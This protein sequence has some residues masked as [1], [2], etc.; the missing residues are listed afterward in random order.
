M[1]DDKADATTPPPD[2]PSSGDSKPATESPDATSSSGPGGAKEPDQ[3]DLDEAYLRGRALTTSGAMTFNRDASIEDLQ[4]GDRYIYYNYRFSSS[5]GDLR[6]VPVRDEVLQWV[7]SRYVPVVNYGDLL[8]TLERMQVLVLNGRPDTGRFTT[9]LRLLNAFTTGKISRVDGSEELAKFGESE[10]EDDHGY[11]VELSQPQAEALTERVLEE[12]AGKLKLKGAYFVVICHRDGQDHMLGEFA[13]PCLPPD[14]D[15]LILSHL[16]E[17]LRDED[18]DI[19]AVIQ[20]LNAN[21]GLRSALAAEPKPSEV[22]QIAGFLAEMARGEIDLSGVETRAALLVRKQVEEWFAELAGPVSTLP[23]ALRLT[24]FRISLAVFNSSEYDVVVNAG[25]ALATKLLK[26]AKGEHAKRPEESLFAEDHGVN[27]PASRATMEDGI[28]SFGGVGTPTKLVMFAD[29]RFPVVLL[30]H[31]WHRHHKL[32]EAVLEWLTELSDDSRPMVW[33]RAAQTMGLFCSLSFSGTFTENIA[34]LAETEGVEGERRRWFAAIALDQAARDERMTDAVFER[35]QEW[36]RYGNEAQQWT[37]AMALGYDLGL[38]RIGD[39]LRELRVLGTP[40]ERRS[41]LQ[42]VGHSDL[43]RVAGYSVANLLAFG[44]V[45]SV[46]LQLADWTRSE[47][48]SVRELARWSIKYL[49]FL[50][51]YDRHRLVHSVGRSDRLGTMDRKRWP[52]LLTLVENDPSRTYEISD[53]VRWGLRSRDRGEVMQRL[54]RLWVH[55]AEKDPACLDALAAF[56]PHLIAGHGDFRRL[57]HLIERMR[58]DWSDPVEENTA[59][60][61]ENAIQ[62]HSER[63]A[64]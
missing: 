33:V 47:R 14:V 41:G 22:A 11:L 40:S 15:D 20:Q 12:L 55:T 62:L 52:L 31:L 44:E 57:Q 34:P 54:F 26:K 10:L 56:I 32:R 19:G 36:R 39:A 38:R 63:T 48:Q 7:R 27:L 64:S 30:S 60:V 8:D 49:I 4:V 1:S 53:L 9:A 45:P 17:D 61:L 59:R 58:R 43:V 5:S 2:P 13:R 24:A 42:S 29:D 3:Q 46:L 37:A 25:G 28:V 18:C 51:G 16:R 50:R 35:L 23:E 21:H 6:A